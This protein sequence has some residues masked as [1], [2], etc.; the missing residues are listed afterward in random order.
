[1]K[2]TNPP[3]PHI[4]ELEFQKINQSKPAR[5]DSPLIFSNQ[6]TPSSH[7]SPL[8]RQI[9]AAFGPTIATIGAGTVMGYSATLLPELQQEDTEIEIN[10]DSAS[11]I[12]S[13]A[14]VPMSVGCLLGG[15]IIEQMGRR[16][17]HM[18]L[19]I[20]LLIGWV[21]I[22]LSNSLEMLLVGRVFGGLSVGLMGPSCSVYL[23]EMSDPKYRGLFLGTP[24]MALSIGI[25]I[26]HVT[27]T[28]MPWRATALFACSFPVLSYLV[29]SLVPESPSWLISKDRYN[30]AAKSFKWLRG[31]GPDQENEFRAMIVKRKEVR[32]HGEVLPLWVQFKLN[33]RKPEFYKAFVIV[34]ICFITMQFTGPNTVTFY[35]VSLMKETLGSGI[36]EYLA[37]ILIDVLRVFMSV[38]ACVLL[39]I[40]SRR[41]LT[42]C[43]GIGT[44]ISLFGLALYL[45]IARYCPE[46]AV[47]S[48]PSL[49]FLVTYIIFISIGIFP[50]PWCMSGELLPVVMR[51]FG[52]SI[53]AMFNFIWCFIVIKTAPGMFRSIGMDGTFFVYGLVC[54]TGTVFLYLLMPETKNKTLAQIEEQFAHRN[55]IGNNNNNNNNNKESVR[56]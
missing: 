33:I 49:L 3:G 11:W 48:W 35:S 7:F 34:F 14:L 56:V 5:T 24:S 36:N 39:R 53:N 54:L 4:R 42:I 26:V 30:E 50:I 19:S 43:S 2:L 46:L 29:I 40:S 37:M 6:T 52:S 12:A 51:S 31:C 8:I 13:L 38:M 45:T 25:L 41:L 10:Q 55:R 18:I 20:P 17:A 47:Y 22:Y 15:W 1:M 28:L 23:S 21:L 16:K 32:S 44:T 27:G 9:L